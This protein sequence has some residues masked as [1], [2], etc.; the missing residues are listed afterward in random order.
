MLENF[1]PLLKSPPSS[2]MSS[3]EIWKSRFTF[4]GLT[5]FI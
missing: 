4:G 1:D 3:E 2:N 5:K